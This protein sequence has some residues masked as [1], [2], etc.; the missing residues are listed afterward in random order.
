MLSQ[1]ELQKLSQEAELRAKA[2]RVIQMKDSQKV[3]YIEK[4]LKAGGFKKSHKNIIGNGWSAGFVIQPLP[5]KSSHESKLDLM[6]ITYQL[7]PAQMQEYDNINWRTQFLARL[8]WILKDETPFTVYYISRKL[9]FLC[10]VEEATHIVI[11]FDDTLTDQTRLNAAL[12]AS[13][14]KEM[15]DTNITGTLLPA[16]TRTLK[17][18]RVTPNT[19]NQ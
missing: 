11:Q 10:S 1:D 19:L 15:Q 18:I 13:K 7:T 14:H 3:G 8:Y 17:T 2:A 16:S 6:L 12:A 4:K 5:L 9:E